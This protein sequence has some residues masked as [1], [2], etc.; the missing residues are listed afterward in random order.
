MTT[1]SAALAPAQGVDWRWLESAVHTAWRSC[2]DWPCD[3]G[4]ADG[5]WTAMPRIATHTPI[6]AS[7]AIANARSFTFQ[8]MHKWGVTD[9][10]DDVAAVVTEL[11]TNAIR[12]ALPQ[13]QQAAGTVSRVAHQ[14]R[15]AASRLTRHLRGRGPEHRAARAARA[16]LAGRVGPRAARRLL[17]Q[18]SLGLLRRAGRAGQGRVERIR[19]HRSPVLASSLQPTSRQVGPPASRRQARSSGSDVRAPRTDAHTPSLAAAAAIRSAD[20]VPYSVVRCR[21]GRPVGATSSASW[22]MVL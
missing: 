22:L 7:H 20:G 5:S 18:R 16:R 4:G 11:L 10:A 13:A 17:A 19:H 15:P 3:Q 14:G 2:R 6:P 12:H 1:R 21:S 9:R 8:T